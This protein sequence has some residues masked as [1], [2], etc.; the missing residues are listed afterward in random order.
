MRGM[1]VRRFNALVRGLPYESAW[2]AFIRD[3]DSRD[4]IDCSTPVGD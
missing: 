1:T 3:R 4:M 2:Q